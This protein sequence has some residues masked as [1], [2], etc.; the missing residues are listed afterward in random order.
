[1]AAKKNPLS[2]LL[3]SN[4]RVQASDFDKDYTVSSTVGQA[5]NYAIG[6]SRPVPISQTSMGRL[7]EALGQTSGILKE[8]SDYQIKKDQLALQKDQLAAQLEGQDIAAQQAVFELENAKLRGS[9]L[10]ETIKQQ[11]IKLDMMQQERE[12]ADFNAEWEGKTPEE[13]REWLASSAQMVKETEEKAEK[14]LARATVAAAKEGTEEAQ[15]PFKALYAA[16]KKGAAQYDE[17]VSFFNTNSQN[18]FQFID[19]TTT[20]GEAQEAVE[21]IINDFMATKRIE[22]GS[23]E[24]K[25][26]LQ[27]ASGFLR[28]GIPQTVDNLMEGVNSL[29]IDSENYSL[30]N[31]IKGGGLLDETQLASLEARNYQGN[32]VEQL[33]GKDGTGKGGLYRMV[34]ATKDPDVIQNFQSV[35]N[36]VGELII[37]GKPYNQSSSFL[38]FTAAID[39]A[40]EKAEL[41]K[42]K[43]EALE[44]AKSKESANEILIGLARTTE[45]EAIKG[46]LLSFSLQGEEG[47]P[48]EPSV[49][50]DDISKA[51]PEL[52][53]VVRSIPDDKIN[54]FA[55]S[56]LND[57]P[58]IAEQVRAIPNGFISKLA[59]HFVDLSGPDIKD[60]EFPFLNVKKRFDIA[61]ESRRRESGL[62]QSFIDQGGLNDANYRDFDI[63][64]GGVVSSYRKALQDLPERMRKEFPNSLDTPEAEKAINNYLN[65]IN[66]NLETGIENYYLKKI[67]DK[68]ALLKRTSAVI[69]EE[70]IR[71]ALKEAPHED[72]AVVLGTL[73]ETLETRKAPRFADTMKDEDVLKLGATLE[74]DL[75]VTN[76]VREAQLNNLKSAGRMVVDSFGYLFEDEDW[77]YEK[78]HKA[79]SETELLRIKT[80]MDSDEA[81]E[82]AETAIGLEKGEVIPVLESKDQFTV[83]EQDRKRSALAWVTETNED[84]MREK[85]LRKLEDIT[86]PRRFFFDN[87]PALTDLKFEGEAPS[88]EEDV[89][90]AAKQL[91]KTEQQLKDIAGLYGYIDKPLEFLQAQYKTVYHTYLRKK[92]K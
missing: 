50:K 54:E 32:F 15:L 33:Y 60:R 27:A 77:H 89:A 6:Y 37:N 59:K 83:I 31:T 25:G 84:R 21:Q 82:Y 68:D 16:S 1:M 46:K 75:K 38:A 48:A 18:L 40:A 12:V 53:E 87:V 34:I 74:E 44:Y 57:F 36:Q 72:Q 79:F 7:A 23:Q 47:A 2:S 92:N 65:Q 51:I 29:S 80:G 9:V 71:K 85:A 78:A 52:E 73:L 30:F 8:F 88:T 35:H 3:Q 14:A 55:Y 86:I 91:G 41:E 58:S 63:K 42:D 5:G 17:F 45:I 69:S 64:S 62:I 10:N 76:E 66:E 70:R 4:R 49:L 61:G 39:E 24:A 22:A 26:L 11:N 56:L 19:E 13:R 28:K 81:L 20:R 43:E 90:K 67:R